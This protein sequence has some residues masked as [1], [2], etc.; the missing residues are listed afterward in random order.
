MQCQFLIPGIL[1]RPS[2]AIRNVKVRFML[3]SPVLKYISW[4]CG[5]LGLVRFPYN[6]TIH[7]NSFSIANHRLNHPRE[8]P[9]KYLRFQVVE[10]SFSICSW[11]SVDLHCTSYRLDS[12]PI[13]RLHMNQGFQGW[14]LLYLGYTWVHTTYSVDSLNIHLAGSISLTQ[15]CSGA[16]VRSTDRINI[17]RVIWL[18]M[19]IIMRTIIMLFLRFTR[20]KI[21][22]WNPLHPMTRKI[23]YSVLT[24]RFIWGNRS[25]TVVS[26]S[27]RVWA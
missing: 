10:V 12:Y 8:D 19:P 2:S 6:H 3:R 13:R 23:M 5:S 4:S 9:G 25:A 27:S 16:T 11:V 26:S 17:V 7:W 21:Q 14:K 24:R 1:N 18:G 22:P 15:S 20:S